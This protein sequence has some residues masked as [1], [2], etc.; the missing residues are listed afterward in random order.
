MKKFLALFLLTFVLISTVSPNAKAS[1]IESTASK[2]DIETYGV[3]EEKDIS[4]I[5]PAYLEIT[6][7]IGPVYDGTKDVSVDFHQEPT[8]K[9]EGNLIQPLKTF[10]GD[11]GTS[12]LDFGSTGNIINWRI[13]PA[14]LEPWVFAGEL[15]VYYG[16]SLWK[17][18]D[19]TGAGVLGS[20]A[21]DTI[22]LGSMKTGQYTF[23]LS[24][25]A[26]A[27][28]GDIEYYTVSS[29]AELTIYK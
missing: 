19:L 24:G 25:T 5:N 23:R 17:S 9:E 12:G 10:K 2:T 11:G 1:G 15:R 16:G 29:D 18:Y 3:S 20:T 28:F 6:D 4:Q 7:I 14:T 22:E 21:S 8:L 26:I 27:P 13:K